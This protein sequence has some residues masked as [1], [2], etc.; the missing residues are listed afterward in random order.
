MVVARARA[1]GGRGWLLAGVDPE[2]YCLAR[3]VA[4]AFPESAVAAGV[5]PWEAARR[6]AA[7]LDRA[8]DWLGQAAGAPHVVALGETGLDRLRARTE[9]AWARQRR[10]FDEHLRL[11]HW[12]ALPLVLHV[13]R[14]QDAALRALGRATGGLRGVVHGFEGGPDAARAYLRRDLYLGFGP[15]VLRSPR[16]LAAAASCPLD[17]L[18]LETD[19][20]DRPVPGV[21]PGLGEPAHLVRVLRAVAAARGLAPAELAHHSAQAAARL[22]SAAPWGQPG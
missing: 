8:L 14:A 20:P 7:Q 17:R 9:D 6:D 18:L 16:A 5:H 3:E 22:F 12:H 2:R 21:A 15:G 4:R 11:A 1:A 13:V 10:A 19:A